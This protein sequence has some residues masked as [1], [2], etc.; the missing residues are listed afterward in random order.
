[1]VDGFR[2]P[3]CTWCAGNRGID[4]AVD[5]GSAVASVVAGTVTFAGRVVGTGYVVVRSSHGVLVTHGGLAAITAHRGDAV[6]PGD[7][8]GVSGSALYIGVR[9]GGTYVDPLRCSTTGQV[10]RPRAVLVSR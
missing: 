7:A 4:Y 8:L 10:A 2:A 6:R 3:A 1:M 5:P 9:V